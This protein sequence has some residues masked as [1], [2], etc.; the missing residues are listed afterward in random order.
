MKPI[1]IVGAG[2][3]AYTLA[4]EVR[5]LDQT[6]PLT[7]VSADDAGFYSKPML[8]NAFAQNRQPAQL[9]TQ[10]AEQMAAQLDATILP[11][12][13]VSAIDAAARTITTAAGTLGYASLVLALGAHAIRLPI[14]GDGANQVM[15]VNHMADY[16]ALRTHLD[17]RA[18][19]VTILG[20]GLIG[21]EFADDLSAG[22]H[23]VT[24]IDPNHLPLGLLAA[25]ALSLALQSALTAR[26]VQMKLGTTA[27]RIDRH[28][29]GLR[30]TL[31]DGSVL[32][33]DIVLSAVGLRPNVTLAQTA[34]LVVE[35]GIV[36]DDH[37]RTSAA[38]IY[39]LGDCAE[40]TLATN[41]ANG[42]GMRT[43]PYVAP[44]MAAARAI[45]RTLCGQST[46]IEHKVTPVLVKTPSLP[47]A[48]VP[49]P[50]HAPGTWHSEVDDKGRTISR[51]ADANGLLDGFGVAPHDMGLRNKLLAELGLPL[52]GAPSAN[53]QGH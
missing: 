19:R 49:P 46:P 8:S 22:G 4:R 7:I 43:M 45:A 5:K 26:G 51:H 3:A 39:A 33:S 16:A 13:A 52:A 38:D 21:C 20:A 30:L 40:Y 47:M 41:G 37:G 2:L 1:I 28:D 23:L 10:S 17:G 14:G 27:A 25:P 32:D 34:D 15:S 50:P 48:L 36:V 24:L 31:A 11:G 9:I 42:A 53:P 18:A 29:Q 6:T 35:R 44:L 12:I